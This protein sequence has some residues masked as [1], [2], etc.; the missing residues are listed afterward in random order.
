MMSEIPKKAR[1]FFRA[2]LYRNDLA[3]L[4]DDFIRRF[5]PSGIA[6]AMKSI[7][8]KD[9]N[10]RR[11]GEISATGR[12][13]GGESVYEIIAQ[14]GSPGEAA[15]LLAERYPFLSGDESRKSLETVEEKN[16][17]TGFENLLDKEYFKKKRVALERWY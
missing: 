5:H 15:A 16:D 6:G 2:L 17:F 14:A 13:D 11:T 7:K 1:P 4:K 3:E 9:S 12:G 10:E 8:G